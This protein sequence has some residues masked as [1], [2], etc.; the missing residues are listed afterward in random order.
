MIENLVRSDFSSFTPDREARRYRFSA[1][2]TLAQ[3]LIGIVCPLAMASQIFTSWNQLAGWLRA[4][5]SLR[6]AA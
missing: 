1:P 6:R 2:G 5:D 3:F 4:M